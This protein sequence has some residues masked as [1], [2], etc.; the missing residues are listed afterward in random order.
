MDWS[1]AGGVKSGK[2]RGNLFLFLRLANVCVLVLPLRSASPH[3]G[4]T[5]FCSSCHF[6]ELLSVLSVQGE[7]E[8][9][10]NKTFD[11]HIK[12]NQQTEKQE[13]SKIGKASGVRSRD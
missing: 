8:L 7:H 10:T 1:G 12:K 11:A 6:N 9:S 2:D 13:N 3:L 5:P 4:L